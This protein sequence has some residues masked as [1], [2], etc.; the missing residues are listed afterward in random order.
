MSNQNMDSGQNP[1]ENQIE[2]LK[3]WQENA[4]NP[5]YYI[6]SGKAPLP[7]RNM[8]K[9]PKAPVIMLIVGSLFAVPALYQLVRYFSFETL[10]GSFMPM[11]VGIIL[12]L[13]GAIRIR[14]I[15]K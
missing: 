15:K 6:G 14:N 10:L 13:G 3:E 9:S 11:A 1:L 8:A 7:L 4:Y 12:M 2:E 5:G